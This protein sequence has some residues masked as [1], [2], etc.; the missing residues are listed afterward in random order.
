MTTF[1]SAS[2]VAKERGMNIR[3]TACVMCGEPSEP[4]CWACLDCTIET[5]VERMAREG[6]LDE[7]VQRVVER[8]RG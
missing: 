3:R 5:A 1:R 8:M 6:K 7:V 2:D 4:V